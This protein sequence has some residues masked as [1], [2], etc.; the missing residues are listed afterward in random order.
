[1]VTVAVGWG[2]CMCLCLWWLRPLF[3]DP[4]GYF[5]TF[6]YS[7]LLVAMSRTVLVLSQ[8]QQQ[9]SWPLWW[10]RVSTPPWPAYVRRNACRLLLFHIWCVH[11]IGTTSVGLTVKHDNNYLTRTV[12]F[13]GLALLQRTCHESIFP[14]LWVWVRFSPHG[15]LSSWIRRVEHLQYQNY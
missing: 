2:D 8:W 12:C 3:K 5:C 4:T 7:I 13:L 15:C 9:R 14:L 1:M 6:I 11:Y 10:W